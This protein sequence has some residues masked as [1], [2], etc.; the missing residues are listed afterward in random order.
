[1]GEVKKRK[2]EA[3][4]AKVEAISRREFNAMYKECTGQD[5]DLTYNTT[6]TIDCSNNGHINLMKNEEPNCQKAASDEL[7]LF[8]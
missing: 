2:E 3:E 6:L 7:S 5:I 4:K 8:E 1:M